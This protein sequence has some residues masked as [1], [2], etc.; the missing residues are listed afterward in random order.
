M[1]AMFWIVLAVFV[2][3]DLVVVAIVVRRMSAMP[4]GIELPG[5]ANRGRILQAAHSLVGEYLRVN[6]SGDPG[7]LPAALVG[8][9]PRLRDLL[10][11][12]RV[13]PAPEVI[14]AFVQVSAAR[15]RVATSQQV[16]DALATIG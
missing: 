9:L 16:R 6:Y 11:G 13:E 10:R 7:A 4:W 12:Q 2:L 15:H 1:S 3:T 5:G 14:K 8:L